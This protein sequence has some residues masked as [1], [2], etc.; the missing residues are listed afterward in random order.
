VAKDQISVWL[1]IALVTGWT[2]P[3]T[4]ERC[5]PVLKSAFSV[6]SLYEAKIT[7]PGGGGVGV[8]VGF[9]VGV[10]VGVGPVLQGAGRLHGSPLPG[11]PLLPGVV[12]FWF[13]VQNAAV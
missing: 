2:V 6:T 12:G 1:G 7:L 5:K 8:G 3:V 10:G 13:C 9:G 11:G 4:A